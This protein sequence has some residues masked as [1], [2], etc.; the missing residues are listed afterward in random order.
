MIDALKTGELYIGDNLQVM[1]EDIADKCVDLIYLDPPFNSKKIYNCNFDDIGQ[2]DGFEDTWNYLDHKEA[3][4]IEFKTIEL[5]HDKLS[6]FLSFIKEG[7]SKDMNHFAYLT[8]MSARLKEMH[9]I[10]KPTGSIYLHIDPTESH[11]LKVI[12][13]LIFGEENFRNEIVWCYT[14]P[15]NIKTN[16]PKKHDIILRYSKTNNYY[17]NIDAV[18]I[19]YKELHTDKGKGAKLWGNNGKLQDEKT[20]QKYIDRGKLP[21]DFWV[22]IPSGGHI[23]PKERLGY[24]TQK[25][26]ALLERIISASC[27]PNGIVFDPFCGC[28]TSCAVAAKKGLLY[29]GIDRTQIAKD[30]ILKRF[31]DAGVNE[32]DVTVRPPNAIEALRLAAV[33][34]YASQ[35]EICKKLGLRWDG[36]KGAD[37]GID[38]KIN[39]RNKD[40]SIIKII[41]SIKSGSSTPTQ[42]RELI[43][44]TNREHSDI[45]VFI[46]RDLPTRGM[47]E[48]LT[49]TGEY[50]PGVPKI[51]ILTIEDV[52]SGKK[53]KLPEGAIIE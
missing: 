44:V 40:G 21:E 34:K 53:I 26:E 35:R 9:R 41:A 27:P 24:P 39:Y 19:P 30:V 12:M 6:R 51:Q 10:L 15:S 11:Y 13:D 17:F 28:G 31:K 4:D 45:G 46:I 1:R 23:S 20:R 42:L 29:I 25:P 38:G 14:G 49:Y 16:F 43:T 48:E 18:R 8:F 22:D 7:A 33:D 52:F 50:K 32:P 47:K 2:V 36:K 3:T 37:K 5:D